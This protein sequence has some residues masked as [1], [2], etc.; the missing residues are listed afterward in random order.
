MLSLIVPAHDEAALLGPTLDALR[1]AASALPI[2]HELIVVD[3]A[4]TDATAHIAHAHGAR[5][6]RIARRHIAAARNAG[7]L[8]ARGERLLFVD[9]DTHVD[10]AVLAAAMAA[11]DAGAVGGGAAVRLHGERVRWLERACTRLLMVAF[12]WT[13]IAPG[14]FVFCTRAAFDAVGGFDERW[15]AGEDVAMSRALAAHGRF[16]ILRESVLTSDRKLRTF[17]LLDHLRLALRL[18]VRGRRVLRSRHALGLWYAR[19]R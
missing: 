3:D 6:S 10:A 18:L 11:L 4:S 8:A 1:R 15:Y 5:V 9:A 19:R 13:T 7:A 2:A 12:R 16:V 14:C 17:S